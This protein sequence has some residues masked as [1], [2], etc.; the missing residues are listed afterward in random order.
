MNLSLAS[1]RDADPGADLSEFALDGEAFD[2]P[3][4]RRSPVRYF[5]LSQRRSGSFMLCRALIRA[6]LGVPHEYFQPD[7]ARVLAGRWGA[8]SPKAGGP[9]PRDFLDALVRRRTS[10][11]FFGAK[12]QYWE[13]ETALAGR[14]GDL[15]LEGGRF[16]YLYRRDLLAQ[17]VSF[18]LAEITGQWGSDGKVSTR[19]MRKEDPFDP[20]GVDRKM[21]VLLY[22]ELGWRSFMARRN[23]EALFVSYEEL[24]ADPRGVL[25][26][27]AGHLG[28]DPALARRV[29]P[30]PPSA[31]SREASEMKR[32]MLE[33]YLA[34]RAARPARG[35]WDHPVADTLW[36]RWARANGL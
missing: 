30:E 1:S 23:I 31:F 3:P 9:A 7:H 34:R 22:D 6:G 28:A 20:A 36:R 29:D 21:N 18:R 24:R 14:D 27:V 17:A 35:A 33:A 12:V 32:R 11:G 2:R 15:F 8:S 25:A 16:V 10:G 26:R 4:P 5:I 13:H 19:P